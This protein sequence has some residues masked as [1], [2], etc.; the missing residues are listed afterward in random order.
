MIP[1]VAVLLLLSLLIMLGGTGL[2]PR[3]VTPKATRDVVER[4]CPGLDEAMRAAS[5][6]KTK[7]AVLS[8]S[9]CGIRKSTLIVNLPGSERAAVENLDAI[10]GALGHGL[11]KLRGDPTDCGRMGRPDTA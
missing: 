6:A 10:I 7:Y 5:L 8:R 3:D 9:V 11:E 1:L 4:F 2:A